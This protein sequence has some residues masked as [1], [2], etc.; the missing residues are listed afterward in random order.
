MTNLLNYK[1]FDYKEKILI[2]WL[3]TLFSYNGSII[4]NNKYYFNGLNKTIILKNQYNFLTENFF[5]NLEKINTY[6]NNS[7]DNKHIYCA[8]YKEILKFAK[9]NDFVFLDPPYLIKKLG[10]NY[11]KGEKID[12]NFV[13]ELL[14]ECKK[15]DKKGVKWLMTQIDTNEIKDLFKN[16]NIS[17]IKVYRMSKKNF[18]TELIIRNY[19]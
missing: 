5:N 7:V 4:V 10:F 12:I 9:K 8:D 14:I 19:N 11:N 15:L 17:E 13:Q 18:V 16:Y 3:M 1:Y 2:F 6:F